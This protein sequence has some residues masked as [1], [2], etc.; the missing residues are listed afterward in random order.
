MSRQSNNIRDFT[1]EIRQIKDTYVEFA[2]RDL[3]R[4]EWAPFSE[5]EP[6][7]R[8]QQLLAF[9]KAA[10]A[11]GLLHLEGVRLLDIGCGNGRQLR[12]YLAMGAEIGKLQGIDLDEAAIA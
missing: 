12:Q 11:K 4:T 10:R 1:S 2:A 5:N 6:R 9:S 3:R 8:A 7:V